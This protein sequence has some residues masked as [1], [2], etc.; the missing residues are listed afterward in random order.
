M[1]GKDGGVVL[2]VS[3]MRAVT[4]TADGGIRL[5]SG[6]T[7]WDV[8]ELLYKSYGVTLPGGSCYSVGLGGHVVGVGRGD[9]GGQPDVVADRPVRDGHQ[10]AELLVRRVGD[11]HEVVQRLAHLEQL[12]GF[13]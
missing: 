1:V 3:G 5:E 7:N 2:D 4:R 8:Y 9:V 11:G 12:P 6:C 10:P 13:R